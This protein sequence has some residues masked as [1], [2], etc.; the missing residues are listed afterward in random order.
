MSEGLNATDDDTIGAQGDAAGGTYGLDWD[1]LTS[2]QER[3]YGGEVPEKVF[4]NTTPLNNNAASDSADDLQPDLHADTNEAANRFVAVWQTEDETLEGDG[5]IMFLR[6]L[7]YATDLQNDGN[8]VLSGNAMTDVG[9]DAYPKISIDSVSQVYIV[10]WESDEN[11][12]DAI[13]NDR[14]IFVA[15]S[16]NEGSTW[17]SPRALNANAT[18]DTGDDANPDVTTDSM[19][20][21]IVAWDS[22]DDLGGTIDTDNDILVARSTSPFSDWSYPWPLSMNAVSDLGRDYNPKIALDKSIGLTVAVW[23]S[24]EDLGGTVGNDWDV[25]VGVVSTSPVP[26]PSVG[27]LLLCGALGLTGLAA[28]KGRA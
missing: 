14:D 18:G 22:A 11:L 28:M 10:V 13:G 8:Q 6:A 17:T 20:N 3:V 27:L 25:F 21:G 24:D 5:D 7:F 26:E 19:G 1:I 15:S 9:R 23:H 4:G 2:V 12:D 16:Q